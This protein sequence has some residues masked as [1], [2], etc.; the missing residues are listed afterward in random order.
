MPMLTLFLALLFACGGP[1]DCGHALRLFHD[2]IRA[3]AEVMVRAGMSL[4]NAES[5][6]LYR[7]M[8]AR[9]GPADRALEAAGAS[10][11]ERATHA[12]RLRHEARQV[13]RLLMNDTAAREALRTR[14]RAKYGDP[15]GPSLHWLY[16]RQE[17][18]GIFGDQA[19]LAIVDSAQR[20]S[21]E[22]TA[23]AAPSRGF[24]CAGAPQDAAQPAPAE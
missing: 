21:P 7:C 22:A 13:S 19:F 15:D 23:L 9:I 8:V 20:V 14:D 1:P 2:D 10:P 6:D 18:K 3:E 11:Q 24:S 4:S 16:A 12:W 5:R 17:A